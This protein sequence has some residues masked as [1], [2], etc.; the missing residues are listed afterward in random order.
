MQPP[1][2]PSRVGGTAELLFCEVLG[3]DLN[4][5]LFFLQLLHAGYRGGIHATEFGAPLVECGNAD[6]DL[7][8]KI[9]YEQARF[10]V[11]EHIHDLTV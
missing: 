3:G 7:T 5:E 11:L 9:M 6:A 2:W 4:L 1:L 10:G 8:A